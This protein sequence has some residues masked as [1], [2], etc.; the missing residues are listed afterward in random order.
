VEKPV[1]ILYVDDEEALLALTKRLL[2][3]MGCQVTAHSDPRQALAD[4]QARPAEFDV[5]IT[6][7]SMP[8]L[9]GLRL[10][11]EVRKIR[12]DI[13]AAVTTGCITPEDQ[14]EVGKLGNVKLIQKAS[15]IDEFMRQLAPIVTRKG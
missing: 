4:F 15:A 8:G 9:S 1:H 11:A 3:R 12:S 13:S 5:L 6:D 2:V 14:E 10:I 7:V